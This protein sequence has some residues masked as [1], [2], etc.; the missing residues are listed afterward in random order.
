MAHFASRGIS[1]NSN[2]GSSAPVVDAG[3]LSGGAYYDRTQN[4][5]LTPANIFWARFNRLR[6]GGESMSR[7]ECVC[8]AM[9]AMK[10]SPTPALA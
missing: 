10:Y 7:F 1:V 4:T 5:L 9:R 6:N 2:D 3:G 8:I